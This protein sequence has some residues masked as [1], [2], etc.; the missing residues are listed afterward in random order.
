MI[1]IRALVSSEYSNDK[2]HHHHAA[3]ALLLLRINVSVYAF[4]SKALTYIL[5]SLSSSCMSDDLW[6]CLCRYELMC[7]MCA[8]VED[9]VD[10]GQRSCSPVSASRQASRHQGSEE[11]KLGSVWLESSCLLA[12]RSRRPE[13][14]ARTDGEKGSLTVPSKILPPRSAPGKNDENKTHSI[15]PPCRTHPACNKHHHHQHPLYGQ[16]AGAKETVYAKGL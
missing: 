13:T 7:S 14:T 9:Q 3:L 16:A 6:P 8:F 5:R 2:H 10:V 11:G 4:S 1:I 15:S 12:L